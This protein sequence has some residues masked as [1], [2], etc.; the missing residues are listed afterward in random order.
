MLLLETYEI[1]NNIDN[2]ALDLFLKK[3]TDDSPF[4]VLS[5]ALGKAQQNGIYTLLESEMISRALREVDVMIYKEN[6]KKW[7]L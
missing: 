1:D 7:N 4:V 3:T 6:N 5:L 2:K